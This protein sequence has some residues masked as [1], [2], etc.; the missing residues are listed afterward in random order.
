[1]RGARR[2]NGWFRVLFVTVMLLFCAALAFFA[3]DQVRLKARIDDLTLSLETSR[4]REARQNHEYDEAVAALPEAKA[5]LERVQP[6]AEAAKAEEAALRQQRKD[7]RAEIAALERQI[8]EAQAQL[9]EL[10]EQAQALQIP[11]PNP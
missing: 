4:G 5:D 10:T 7:V 1:M 11:T 2:G 6:L 9:D 3:A 8:A